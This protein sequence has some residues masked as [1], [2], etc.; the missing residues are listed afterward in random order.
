MQK[1]CLR[2]LYAIYTNQVKFH[3]NTNVIF[4]WGGKYLTEF[5]YKHMKVTRPIFKQQNEFEESKN[6]IDCHK[7]EDL[8]DTKPSLSA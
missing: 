7:T 2:I 5:Y 8:P 1:H 4:L 6:E 3:L